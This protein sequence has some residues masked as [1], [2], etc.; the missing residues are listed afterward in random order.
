MIL[1]IFIQMVD[2]N[3]PQVMT[4]SALQLVEFQA[5]ISLLMNA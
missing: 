5:G 3:W 2:R 4:N 1:G